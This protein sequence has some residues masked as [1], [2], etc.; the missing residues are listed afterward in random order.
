MQR[1]DELLTGLPSLTVPA[2]QEPVLRKDGPTAAIMVSGY[3]G[4]GMHVFFSVVRSFPGMFRNF[5]FLSAG[6][7]DSSTFKGVE[8]IENRNNFV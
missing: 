1:L 6:V 3:N 4:M 2:E 7:I 5:V 8:E